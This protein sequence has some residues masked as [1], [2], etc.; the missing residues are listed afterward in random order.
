M[1]RISPTGLE[2]IGKSWE[3]WDLLDGNGLNWMEGKGEMGDTR[4][5]RMAKATKGQ[6][7]LERIVYQMAKA[8]PPTAPI[9]KLLYQGPL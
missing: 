8:T 4:P 3:E 9:D 7:R 1:R 2:W 5:A 6:L